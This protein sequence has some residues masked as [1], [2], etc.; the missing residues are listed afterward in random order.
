MEEEGIKEERRSN[1]N[2]GKRKRIRNEKKVREKNKR[3][4]V[5]TENER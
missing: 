1:E 4:H 3:N 5:T 2:E